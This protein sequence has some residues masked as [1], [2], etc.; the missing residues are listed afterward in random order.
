MLAVRCESPQNPACGARLLATS[1]ICPPKNKGK[2]GADI[3][4]DLYPVQ[5][6]QENNPQLKRR[7]DGGG[8]SGDVSPN[9][10]QAGHGLSGDPHT[11]RHADHARS[12]ENG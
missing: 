8:I 4:P 7:R 3:M 9:G 2:K 11:Q 6:P 1:D 12:V 10:G 5:P